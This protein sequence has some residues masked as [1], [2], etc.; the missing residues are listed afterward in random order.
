MGP[1]LSACRMPLALGKE[2]GWEPSSGERVW[3]EACFPELRGLQCVEIVGDVVLG[4]ARL[5]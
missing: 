1:S 3:E 5:P 2:G 4:K